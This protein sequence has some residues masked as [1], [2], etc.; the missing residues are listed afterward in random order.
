M[1]YTTNTFLLVELARLKSFMYQNADETI[2]FEDKI[3]DWPRSEVESLLTKYEGLRPLDTVITLAEGLEHTPLTT[4]QMK[5][6]AERL[7]TDILMGP[8]EAFIA[9]RSWH[10][11]SRG[12]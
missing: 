6:I 2:T 9:W 7:T 8:N 12:N 10:G 3:R 11:P 5:N 4:D 1:D